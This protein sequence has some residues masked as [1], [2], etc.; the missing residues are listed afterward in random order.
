VSARRRT[1]LSNFCR[2]DRP[3]LPANGCAR[4]SLGIRL[5]SILFCSAPHSCSII[6]GDPADQYGSN[7]HW[8]AIRWRLAY[9]CSRAVASAARPLWTG[10]DLPKQHGLSRTSGLPE[11]V[12]RRCRP[13]CPPLALPARS[14]QRNGRRLSTQSGR[15]QGTRT[16]R[17]W[18][19]QP[20]RG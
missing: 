4:V 15:S 9:V 5:Y 2:S 7:G 1:G 12:I 17:H 18:T 16:H 11:A 8:G 20:G 19:G 10:A 13:A 6:L 14:G 3:L